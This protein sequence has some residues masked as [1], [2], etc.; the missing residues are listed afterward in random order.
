MTRPSQR[1]LQQRL[2]DGVVARRRGLRLRARAP[3]LHQGRPVRARGDPRRARRA[4]PAAPRVP[5]RRLRRDGG[6]DLLRAPRQAARRRARRR[7]RGDEPPGGQDRQRDRR[8]G[9]RARGRQ[10]LQ[11]LGLRPRGPGGVGRG[12]PRA[13]RGAARLGG[14]G[15]HRLRH[16]RDQRLPRRGA[17]RPARSARSSACR[18]WSPSRACSRRRPTTATTTSR[19]AGSSPTTARR[20]SGL[21]CSRGPETMLP[22]LEAI[23]A[24][25]DVA[26]A[27]QPV[28]VPDLAGDAGLRVAG[29]GDGRHAFPI[30]LEP[31]QCTRFEMAD[32]ALRARDIG[33]DYIGICC[34]GGPHHVRAMAE[35]L[36]RETPASR[37]SPAIELHPVLGHADEPHGG[38]WAAGP[39][40]ISSCSS[41]DVVHAGG[42]VGVQTASPREGGRAVSPPGCGGRVG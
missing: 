26:V 37:Y 20:S 30:Q 42:G 33:V 38:R 12:G 29:A 36:G 40:R 1:T 28:P 17:H 4:A 39:R 10:H 34:G 25:V 22:L 19:R 14:R 31:F 24:A 3:R 32:F 13:V 23:R 27:A 9:R 18:R 2:A 5:A 35:A 8:R 6:A 21:N 41:E 7:A 15:G 16:R 11:H